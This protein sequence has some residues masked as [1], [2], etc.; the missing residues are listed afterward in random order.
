MEQ[1]SISI[2]KELA[3]SVRRVPV[4][5]TAKTSS[6]SEKDLKIQDILLDLLRAEVTTCQVVYDDDPK[7]NPLTYLYPRHLHA[8]LQDLVLVEAPAN[9]KSGFP[10]VAR[11]VWV[12]PEP[13]LQLGFL[14][15][16][17]LSGISLM[18]PDLRQKQQS[19]IDHIK[20]QMAVKD[21]QGLY[22]E[23]GLDREELLA[24]LDKSSNL[25]TINGD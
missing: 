8:N 2:Q 1:N 17:V 5:P 11:L 4:K 3:N 12:D 7:A 25:K 16:W 20:S 15:K 6:V 23:L 18:N 21:T 14:C 10:R 22:G 13:Q 19:I 9:S 24:S